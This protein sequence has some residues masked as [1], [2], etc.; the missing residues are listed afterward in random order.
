MKCANHKDV[1]DDRPLLHGSMKMGVEA[2]GWSS[3]SSVVSRAEE[4]EFSKCLLILRGRIRE[5][6]EIGMRLLKCDLD[7]RATNMY[8]VFGERGD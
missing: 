7:Y 4:G 6:V 3:V 2:H 8:G 1:L 5:Q